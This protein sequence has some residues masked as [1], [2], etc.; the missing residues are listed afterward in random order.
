M[1]KVDPDKIE[2]LGINAFLTRIE[3]SLQFLESPRQP[4]RIKINYGQESAFNFDEKIVRIRMRIDL[5]ALDESNGDIGLTGSY[6]I[7]YHFRIGN[8]EEFIIEKDGLNQVDKDLG[9]TLLSIA[10]S[11]SRG[12]IQ[13][14]TLGTFFKGLI[15]PVINPSILLDPPK[16]VE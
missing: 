11:T 9:M 4:F 8:M 7:D 10:F 15:L 12:I 1:S 14:S 5:F 6:G 2:I 3:P 13:V 16:V